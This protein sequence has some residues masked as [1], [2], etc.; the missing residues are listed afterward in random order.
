MSDDRT[1]L[2]SEFLPPFPAFYDVGRKDYWIQ[3]D[4]GSWI[5]VN[6][7][8]LKR[9]LRAAGISGKCPDGEI[10]SP[11]D[12]G[13]IEIQTKFDV[14]YAGPLAGHKQGVYEVNGSRI[15]VTDS[16]KLIEPKEGNWPL[17]ASVLKSLLNDPIE[18]QRSYFFGWL[19]IAIHAQRAGQPRPGQA[20][21][22]AGPR[23]SGKSLVQNLT[24]VILGGRV[25]KPYRYM[26]DATTFNGELFGA[27]H[28]MIEDE[29]ASTDIR[30]RRA[31]G[32][33]IKEMTVNQMQS[34]HAKNRQAITL[35]PFWRVTISLNDEPENL[36]I[37]PPIDESLADKIML[38]KTHK[39][40]MPMPT[41]TDAERTA[42]WNALLSELPA[43]IFYLERWPIP[44]ELKCERFGITHYHHA[45]LLAA[46]EE[47]SPE[48]RLL[49]L[50]DAT[51]FSHANASTWEGTATALEQEL[52]N[53]LRGREARRLIAWENAIGTYLGR[54][55]KKHPKRIEYVRTDQRRSWRIIPPP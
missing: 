5:V 27:E 37:L 8:S 13:L 40:P 2:P 1:G 9:Q 46:L 30:A 12:T 55:A 42:F 35:T 32:S 4:R 17:I 26:R 31:F 7:T 25:S 50:V 14:A 15:L 3:N 33:R 45:D 54:L 23:D 51:I 53:G 36:L 34:H 20:I 52:Y 47:L 49:E 19:K 48:N 41:H 18:D 21:V 24:T 44:N 16:P 11:L 29:I 10:I 28:L 43:F 6:E 38:L 39:G 22:F